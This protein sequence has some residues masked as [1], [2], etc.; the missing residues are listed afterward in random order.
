[1]APTA[2]W[3][4]TAPLTQSRKESGGATTSVAASALPP[5][6]TLPS[7]QALPQAIDKSEQLELAQSKLPPL[8]PA[9]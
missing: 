5:R 1:M 4:D 6:W 3:T 7:A 8:S 2:A 9:L